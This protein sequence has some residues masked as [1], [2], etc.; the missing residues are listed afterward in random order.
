MEALF[1]RAR[2]LKSE[3]AVRCALS[4][5]KVWLNFLFSKRPSKN[6]RPVLLR[7]QRQA[8]IF[9]P[10]PRNVRLITIR[11]LNAA[12]IGQT[13]SLDVRVATNQSALKKVWRTL[14]RDHLTPGGEYY[15]SVGRRRLSQI[16]KLC[17]ALQKS[18]KPPPEEYQ[19]IKDELQDV[20]IH[21]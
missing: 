1:D 8:Q 2:E 20:S 18:A 13:L 5:I 10:S 19:T 12:C 9:G 4:I 21:S 14:D 6:I 17:R 15:L 3:E 16:H 11:P 7:L